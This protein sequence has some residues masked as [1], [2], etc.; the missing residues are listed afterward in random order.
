MLLCTLSVRGFFL[1]SFACTR[2]QLGRRE[3]SKELIILRKKNK[4]P[5]E[6]RIGSVVFRSSPQ[7]SW[8]DQAGLWMGIS[9]HVFFLLLLILFHVS[10]VV[11]ISINNG[12]KIRRRHSHHSCIVN[13]TVPI[14]FLKR[15]STKELLSK[16]RKVLCRG[17][18]HT[19]QGVQCFSLIYYINTNEIP[20]EL[21]RENLISSHVKISPLLWLHTFHI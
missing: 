5:L 16:Q 4:K 2:M 10:F 14:M 11:H 21:S 7:P 3:K 18:N 6:P 15:A 8:K 20:G 12:S 17:N 13:L 19:P 1:S 9:I